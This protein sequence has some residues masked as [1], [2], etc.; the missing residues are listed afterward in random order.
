VGLHGTTVLI[1]ID[2]QKGELV[3]SDELLAVF[4]QVAALGAAA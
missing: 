1:V 3:T 2:V 4:A